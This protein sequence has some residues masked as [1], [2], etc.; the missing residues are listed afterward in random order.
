MPHSG[1]GDSFRLQSKMHLMHSESCVF[2]LFLSSFLSL[3]HIGS[4]RNDDGSAQAVHSRARV[5][6]P[7]MWHVVPVQS[8]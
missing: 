5:S 8:L 3:R 7:D 4:V 2:W 1:K 6:G